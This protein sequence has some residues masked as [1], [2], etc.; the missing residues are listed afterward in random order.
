MWGRLEGISGAVVRDFTAGSIDAR[1][2]FVDRVPEIIQWLSDNGPGYTARET[3]DLAC[4]TG[5][6]VCT[7]P[8]YSPESNGMAES[9]VKTFKRDYV[10]MNQLPVA[11][12]VL[13]KLPV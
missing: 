3:R 7:T 10:H 12:Y 2:G 11:W 6:E 13:E 8:Y 4:L 9:L 1:F 5:L